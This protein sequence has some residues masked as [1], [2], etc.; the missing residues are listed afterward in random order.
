MAK[1]AEPQQLQDSI[2]ATPQP[3]IFF[4]IFRPTV[5]SG[6]SVE[7]IDS[8]HRHFLSHQ[9]PRFLQATLQLHQ[10]RY[11]QQ[12]ALSGIESISGCTFNFVSGLFEGKSPEFTENAVE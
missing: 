3:C 7:S 2:D 1:Y 5:F 6:F 11:F 9:Q 4:S 12:Q 8:A 10:S